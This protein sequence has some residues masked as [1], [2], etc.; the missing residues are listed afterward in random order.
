MKE[1]TILALPIGNIKDLSLRAK[2]VLQNCQGVLAE[3]T[4]RFKDFLRMAEINSSAKIL[5]FPSFTEQ[6]VNLPQF[7]DSLT[8]EKWI[9]VS[10]AG[11]PGVSDPGSMLIKAARMKNIRVEAVP[12]PS[13]LTLA[14]QMTG[15][16]GLPVVF[17]GFAPK[18]NK[19]E[20]FSQLEMSKT[21]IYFDSKH[22]VLST[23]EYLCEQK[24]GQK[25]LV[26]LR[27]LTKTHEEILDSTV[28]ELLEEFQKRFAGN[29]PLGELTF[30]LEGEGKEAQMAVSTDDLLALRNNSAS[31]AAKVLAKL[32]GISREEA[33]DLLESTKKPC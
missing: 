19:K 2:E 15:G 30:M 17:A 11:T 1:L 28:Q 6:S 14:L 12:G 4:R 3:D 31:Q 29:Q 32:S 22:D 13:A 7:L 5:P 26:V 18:K 25:R 27:E 23:L 9:L 16:F 8:E 21:F 20:F 24:K 10:D 33:Y